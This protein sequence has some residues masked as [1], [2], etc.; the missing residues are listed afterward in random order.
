M[1]PDNVEKMLDKGEYTL[2]KLL[3]VAEALNDSQ[4]MK[5]EGASVE[6]EGWGEG[7]ESELADQIMRAFERNVPE[8]RENEVGEAVL[9][10][11]S[12]MVPQEEGYAEDKEE[13]EEEEVRKEEESEGEISPK[14]RTPKKEEKEDGVKKKNRDG[15]V[16]RIS[17]FCIAIKD[18]GTLEEIVERSQ[19]LY[20][21]GGGSGGIGGAQWTANF[22]TRLLV[23][24]G[25]AKKDG[26]KFYLI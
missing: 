14:E 19:K 7:D 15:K 16:S 13:V 25:F 6:L 11:Y 3:E 9:E 4:P 1:T 20:E 26:R 23:T 12:A 2:E 18:G 8:N 21:D 5:D 22:A 24:L 10:F 17:T